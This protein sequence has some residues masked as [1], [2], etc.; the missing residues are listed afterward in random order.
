[1]AKIAIYEGYGSGP[2]A[3]FGRRRKA[4]RKGGKASHRAKFKK[5]AKACKGKGL[6]AFRACMRAK[7]RK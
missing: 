3:G 4:K 6:R 7:L 1:M 5:A 2:F